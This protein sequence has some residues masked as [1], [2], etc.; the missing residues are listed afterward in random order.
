MATKNHYQKLE[1]MYT[2]AP[3]NQLYQTEINVTEGK[4]EISIELKQ[5]YFH[6]GNA[7]HGAIYFKMLDDAAVFAAASTIQEVFVVTSSFNIHLLRPVSSGII[8][9]RGKLLYSSR[10]LFVAE[11]T[12]FDQKERKI[13]HGTGNFMKSKA[14]LTKEIGYC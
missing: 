3:I 1:H 6:A 13:A 7:L 10:S 5:E 8:T 2:T 14:L 4:C 12:L 9:A 11:A